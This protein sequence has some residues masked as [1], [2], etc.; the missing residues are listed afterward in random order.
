MSSSFHLGSQIAAEQGRF[1]TVR[2]AQQI[3]VQRSATALTGPDPAPQVCRQP[4]T[5]VN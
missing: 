1:A 5:K 4:P 3:G 2:A